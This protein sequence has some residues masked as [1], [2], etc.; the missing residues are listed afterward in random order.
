MMFNKLTAYLSANHST[1]TCSA[2]LSPVATIPTSTNST[3]PI[4]TITSENE[5]ENNAGGGDTGRNVAQAQEKITDLTSHP[6][7]YHHHHYKDSHGKN[8]HFCLFGFVDALFKII[9]GIP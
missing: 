4:A 2:F 9:V 8:Y 6:Y 5:G 1:D 3:N 7:Y